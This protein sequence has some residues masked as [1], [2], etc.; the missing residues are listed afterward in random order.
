[1]HE[2]DNWFDIMVINAEKIK[3][4]DSVSIVKLLNQAKCK[5]LLFWTQKDHNDDKQSDMI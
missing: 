2:T 3:S 5:L 4:S 1:M